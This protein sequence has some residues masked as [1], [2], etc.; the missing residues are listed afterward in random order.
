[1]GKY[2]KTIFLFLNFSPLINLSLAVRLGLGVKEFL[3]ASFYSG[4]GLQ[5]VSFGCQASVSTYI[6]S[7]L[8]YSRK[9][10]KGFEEKRQW[11]SGDVLCVFLHVLF[12][13]GDKDITLCPPAGMI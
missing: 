8:Y 6:H 4:H 11:V 10:W 9:S 3:T 5:E 2:F 13:T 7:L 12:T 1:M